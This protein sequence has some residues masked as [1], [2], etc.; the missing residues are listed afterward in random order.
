MKKV[1]FIVF[2]LTILIG[3]GVSAQTFPSWLNDTPPDDVLWGVGSAKMANRNLSQP[4]AEARARSSISFSLNSTIKS[5]ITDHNRD[6]TVNGVTVSSSL[7]ES[8][9]RILTSSQ[10]EGSRPNKIW[11]APDG[12]AWV[13][14]EYS[15]ELAKKWTR[16]V[17]KQQVENTG[18][19]VDEEKIS[20]LNDNNLNNIKQSAVY[21]E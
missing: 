19:K 3:A 16:E 1:L 8:I 6:A 17:L 13:R 7:Q 4:I 5:A 14:V 11:F 9:T 15:K 18:E 2:I 21:S 12:T 10:L 20:A